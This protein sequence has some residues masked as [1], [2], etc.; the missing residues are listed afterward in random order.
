[1]GKRFIIT[2]TNNIEGRT[3]L[4]YIDTIC[5]NIVLGTNFFSD[6]FAGLT[7]IFGGYSGT[8]KRKLER[9][10][11]DAKNELQ[12]KAKSLGANAII[13]FSI[14]FDEISGQGKSMFMISASGT[15]C[16]IEEGSDLVQES[17]SN[18]V[19]PS[20]IVALALKKREVIQRVNSGEALEGELREF[21]MEYPLEEVAQKV[22]DAYIEGFPYNAEFMNFAHKYFS[23]LPS[24][25]AANFLYSVYAYENFNAIRRIL[26][27]CQ[28]FSPRETLK[29]FDRFTLEYVTNVLLADKKDYISED[30]KYMQQICDRFENLPDTGKI[31]MVKGGMFSKDKEMFVCQKGHANDKDKEFCYSCGVNIKGLTQEQLKSIN[32]FKEKV[33][34]LQSLLHQ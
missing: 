34:I 20:H 28:L 14:D 19:A 30:L 22:F 10:Y 1:M 25:F 9:I 32:L 2:A 27:T 16:V 29:L 11:G 23:S 21:L 33:Q 26:T 18:N 12:E 4:K 8:Y 17:L 7:D 6:F 24:D 13:G 3:I 31:E 15:A 5:V